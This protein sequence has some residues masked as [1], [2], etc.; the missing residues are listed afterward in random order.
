M[1]QMDGFE[2]MAQD[3]TRD[4]SGFIG[5]GEVL[6][7]TEEVAVLGPSKVS[8]KVGVIGSPAPI[9]TG[10]LPA[11]ELALHDEAGTVRAFPH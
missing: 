4:G 5:P 10:R 2:V 9:E 3:V 7:F 6:A 11:E 1:R 8:I